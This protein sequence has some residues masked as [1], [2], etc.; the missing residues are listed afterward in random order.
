MDL[1][2]EVPKKTDSRIHNKPAILEFLPPQLLETPSDDAS[3]S[4]PQSAKDMSLLELCEIVSVVGV[5]HL[6]D[7]MEL[8]ACPPN[9][10]IGLLRRLHQAQQVQ[11]KLPATAHEI[12]THLDAYLWDKKD[13]TFAPQIRQLLA[14]SAAVD[15]DYIQSSS[16]F[17]RN[18]AA[19]SL[20][21]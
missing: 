20:L 8:A 2:E 9:V 14:V 16:I 17:R 1:D 11:A 10:L 4:R 13:F 21:T 19:I 6:L 5:P 7:N 18:L 3:S 15:H 12:L